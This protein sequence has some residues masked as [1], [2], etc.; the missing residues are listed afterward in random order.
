MPTHH[1]AQTFTVSDDDID[2]LTGL[3][4]ER[5]VPLRTDE[6]ARALVEHKL[7]HEASVLE[8]KF[9]DVHVYN[10]AHAYDVDQKVIFPALNYAVAT[11]V[12]TRDGI[13]ADYGDFKVMRVRFDDSD[14][15]G[16]LREFAYNLQTPHTLTAENEN[17]SRQLPGSATFTADDLLALPDVRDV[18]VRAVQTSLSK[19]ADLVNLSGTWFP[20]SLLLEVNEGHLNLAEAV[21]DIVE[22]GPL[23]PEEI[24]VQI[25]GLGNAALSLQLFCLNYALDN[26]SRFDEVGPVN[27]VLWYLRRLEPIEVLNPPL[28]LIYSPIEYDTSLL[29][30]EMK[31]LE[32]EIDDEWSDLPDTSIDGDEV[33]IT[34]N[35]PH[36]R[37][38]TLPLNAR[39]RQVFPTA[40]R[41][42]RIYVTLVDGQDGEEY[43]GWVVRQERYVFGLGALFR[44]HKLPVGARVNIRRGEEPGK[45]IINFS[46]Y[47]PRTEWIRIII[48]RDGQITFEDQKRAIGATYDELMLLG[49]DDLTAVDALFTSM[50]GSRRGITGI[51]KTI[52]TELSRS[53]PQSA[54]HGKTLYSAVNVVRRCP[55]APIFAAMVANPDFEYV[56][57]NYWKLS[58][59]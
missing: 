6:L 41:T 22:G 13:N 7:R 30:P 43:V 23:T 46:A 40:R 57:N 3:L 16:Q 31:S 48:P 32:R 37:V 29:S 50:Q 56:G 5:E 51:V 27:T 52:L 24:L 21:L 9:K 42:P 54:V 35:Y 49:A 33:E 38:G 45:I 25:G 17:G 2:Y 34:L 15:N 11:I 59:A 1:W 14:Q 4:L 58:G 55:P 28:M 39:M 10:P 44:K 53:A 12:E 19:V 36:R 18:L 47:K 26:D 8:D 20:R